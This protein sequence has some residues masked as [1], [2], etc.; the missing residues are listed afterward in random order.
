MLG[1]RAETIVMLFVALSLGLHKF[2]NFPMVETVF[3][4]HTLFCVGGSQGYSELP[5]SL[6]WLCDSDG[7]DGCRP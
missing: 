5:L 4:R 6:I 3:V 2:W 7:E 1:L